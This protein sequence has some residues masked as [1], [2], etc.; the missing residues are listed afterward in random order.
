M[1]P[2]LLD[3]QFATLDPPALDEAPI[4]A[5]IGG[6]VTEIAESIIRV[7]CP[8]VGRPQPI[9]FEAGGTP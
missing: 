6:P 3:S 2:S 9:R 7:L 5:A 4:P 1:P 8:A